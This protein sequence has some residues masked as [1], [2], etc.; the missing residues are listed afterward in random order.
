MKKIASIIVLVIFLF[1]FTACTENKDNSGGS[2][3]PNKT[4]SEELKLNFV[5]FGITHQLTSLSADDIRKSGIDIS[6]LDL[7]YLR[8][9]LGNLGLTSLSKND[10]INLRILDEQQK[11]DFE[12]YVERS[13]N[14]TFKIGFCISND[15]E[16]EN[17]GK[18]I[19]WITNLGWIDNKEVREEL[20][21]NL[22]YESKILDFDDILDAA[23]EAAKVDEFD[24]SF[25][26]DDFTGIFMHGYSKNDEEIVLNFYVMELD[27]EA[28]ANLVKFDVTLNIK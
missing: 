13:K 18:Q 7:E 19:I 16:S 2:I 25:L 24:K 23:K 5:S 1:M 8:S 28:K 9:P 6:E 15:P 22:F 21:Y 12:D 20:G 11:E 27:V 14:N 3:S 26:N 10:I 17:Y 4:Y